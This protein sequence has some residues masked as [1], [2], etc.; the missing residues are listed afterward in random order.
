M[1]KDLILKEEERTVQMVG[2]NSK[3]IIVP[4]TIADDL[5]LEVS[6]IVVVREYVIY[7]R[8]KNGSIICEKDGSPKIEKLWGTFWKKGC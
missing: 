4:S 2:G 6:D 5:K 8:D 1:T 7:A 3:A